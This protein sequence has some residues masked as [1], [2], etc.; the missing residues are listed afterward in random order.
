MCRETQAYREGNTNKL[1]SR[2]IRE[3]QVSEWWRSG[4]I[5]TV[6]TTEGRYLRVLYPG[7]PMPH[8]GPDFRDTLLITEE[9]DLIRGDTEVHL[10]RRDWDGHGHRGDPRYGRVVLHLFLRGGGRPP[11][12]GSQV[13]EVMLGDWGTSLT[14][15]GN[16]PK[17][18]MPQRGRRRASGAPE[19]P[20][21]AGAGAGAGGS[22]G[23]AVPGRGLRLYKA[24][25]GRRRPG[26]A[27]HG[28]YGGAGVQPE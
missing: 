24:S 15:T 14:Q 8:V 18:L 2:D 17:Q 16:P 26:G 27:V 5:K 10:R 3:V 21:L 23:E 1:E 20:A 25:P 7:R 28:R 13:Q 6:V 12:P 4:A 22:R 19:R 11:E 9:G